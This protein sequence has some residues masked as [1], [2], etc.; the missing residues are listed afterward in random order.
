MDEVNICKV[1]S[2]VK[3]KNK[4]K[5]KIKKI[6]LILAE[7]WRLKK[8]IHACFYVNIFLIKSLYFWKKEA[9]TSNKKNRDCRM[10][11]EPCLHLCFYIFLQLLKME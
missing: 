9:K 11:P 7:I 1:L 3:I 5:L 10:S 6:L 2:F 4:K 8:Y